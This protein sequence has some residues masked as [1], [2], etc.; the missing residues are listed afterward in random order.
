MLTKAVGKEIL[1]LSV[2]PNGAIMGRVD[3]T[4]ALQLSR[5]TRKHQRF[6]GEEKW[7][8]VSVTRYDITGP[9]YSK[10]DFPVTW[11][12]SS[13]HNGIGAKSSN[14]LSPENVGESGIL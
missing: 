12:K 9:K 2:Q 13:R 11:P 1:Y 5:I 3:H 4:C 14:T 7:R 6:F 8:V 10:V